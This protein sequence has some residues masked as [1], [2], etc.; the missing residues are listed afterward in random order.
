MAFIS[1][2]HDYD[3]KIDKEDFDE[4]RHIFKGALVNCENCDWKHYTNNTF[5]AGHLAAIH[6]T[7]DPEEEAVVKILVEENGLKKI[8]HEN[9]ENIEVVISGSIYRF[10]NKETDENISTFKF[11]DESMSAETRKDLIK[12]VDILIDT[13]DVDKKIL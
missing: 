8:L 4:T 7:G 13:L 10:R 3:K 6:N 2:P 12:L 1:E 9:P 5:H 11:N